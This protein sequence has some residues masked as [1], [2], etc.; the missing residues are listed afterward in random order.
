MENMYREFIFI[1]FYRSRII[2]RVLLAVF[3]ISIA[4]AVTFPSIYR[5]T[6]KFSLIIPQS[7]DPLQQET[8][9]DY[10]NRVT[11]FLLEQRELVLSNRVLTKVVKELYP[12]SNEQSE[13]NKLIDDI[14]EDLEVV[15]PG[16]E[17]FE[18]SSVYNV[19]YVHKNPEWAYKL[20]S[21]VTQSYLEVFRELTQ[22]K[23]N[24]SHSF[25]TEQVEK[26]LKEMK[27]KE[28]KVHEFE[29]QQALALL[30]ILNLGDKSNTQAVGPNVLLTQFLGNYHSLQHELAGLQASMSSLE[31]ESNRSDIPVIMSDMEIP[32]RSIA[33]FKNKVAQLQ[34]QLN[35]MKPQFTE[36]FEPMKQI[37]QEMMLGVDSLK[38][39]L[40]RSISSQ[41]ITAQSIKARIE[42]LEKTIRELK[43]QIQEIAKQ[44]ATYDALRQGFNIAKD[45]Y[46][47]AQ[48]QMEQARMAQ[49]VSGD[50]QFLTLIDKP[51]VPVRPFKP[52]RFMI[53]LG[54]LLGGLFLGV[55][56]ALT[57]DHFDHRMKTSYEIEKVLG[58][59]VVGS[60]RSL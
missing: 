35:E 37:E 21:S 40:K 47:R 52:N 5:A 55:A 11:R 4:V 36:N 46:S 20:I 10:R 9:F 17:T 54:G 57:V 30:E 42:Q 6:A 59:P 50:K 60:I 14:K 1:V 28:D 27:D 43:D 34:I 25:F 2:I 56:A 39:E 26:L 31:R 7:S 8:A 53:I 32:G 44:K 58:V 38:K 13:I 19:N 3:I 33:I 18:G 48:V 29:T 15:P 16:G 12:G 51:I 45:N 49:S 24:Y 23:T 22:A 41:K